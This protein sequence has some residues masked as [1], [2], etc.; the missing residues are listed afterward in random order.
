MALWGSS[1]IALKIAFV[2]LPPMW[3][4]FGRMAIGSLVFLLAWRWRGRMHYQAGDWKYLLGLAVCEPCLYFVFEALA[5]Q[6]TS[7]AQAGMITAL[8]PLLVAIGAYLALGERITRLT[9]AGF[10]LAVSGAIWMSLVGSADASAPNPL[11]GNFFEF[12]AMLCAMGYTLLL[13]HLSSRYSAFILTAMQAFVGAIFFLPLAL[14]L[15][16]LPVQ[17]GLQGA[18]AVL[19]LGLV[20]TVVAY[21][22]FNFGVSRLPAS[23]ASGF[24]NLIPVFTLIFAVWLLDERLNVLQMAGAVLVF[25]GVALSQWRRPAA[26]PAGVLD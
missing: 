2:E 21:G 19:Y 22:L 8:M 4:I 9:L 11:A 15:Q 10:L 6:N 23:Q 20:V 17:I 12:L 24:V 5:L 26:V 7:A 16:P 14:A 13:K 3:V 1:F 18:L 25:A